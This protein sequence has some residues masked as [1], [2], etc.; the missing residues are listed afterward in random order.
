[1]NTQITAT[2]DELYFY[3]LIFI[4]VYQVNIMFLYL[5]IINHSNS[6]M[7][8]EKEYTGR[9]RALKVLLSIV[10]SPYV[11]TK[12]RLAERYC[13]GKDAIKEDLEAIKT[14]GFDLHYD[15]KYRYA[16]GT[17]RRYENLK[18]LLVF[19]PKEEEL[20]NTAIRT[21]NA[22][23]RMVDRL[24]KKM[25]RLYDVSK[26]NSTFDRSFL[27]KL[28]KLEKAKTDKKAIILRGYRSTNSSTIKDRTVEP[29][30]IAAEDDI[31]HAFDLDARDIRHYKISRIQKLD[32]SPLDWQHEGSH[33]I[34]ATDP[35]R[36]HNNN[37]VRAH[38]RMKVGGFNALLEA[39]PNTRGYLHTVEDAV[40]QYD[41]ICKVNQKFL[42]I[43]NFI[44]GNYDNIISI[45][46]PDELLD[47]IR[48]EIQK[49]QSKNF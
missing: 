24:L 28:D 26:M 13:V 46:E 23:G 20:L 17:E 11:Y 42:G 9:V 6:N 3:S 45:D 8:T 5:S 12:Q 15:K 27:T 39:F 2:E 25:N 44:L 14:A 43:T 30:H 34:Q 35:F 22:D 21:M 18:S 10:E 36:I 1:M 4:F 33:V 38:I 31:L 37:Q 41:L 7:A 32:I 40:G 29:F 19:S 49:L 47:H 48:K 16:L